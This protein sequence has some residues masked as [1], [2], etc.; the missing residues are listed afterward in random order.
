MKTK[1][2][3]KIKKSKYKSKYSSYQG[4]GMY[5]DN[6][7][8]SAGQGPSSTSNI[9]YEESDP[10]LQEERLAKLDAGIQRSQQQAEQTAASAEQT[11]EQGKFKAESDATNVAMAEAQ[12]Q[13]AV[14]TGISTAAT[15]AQ[16]AGLG[17][18]ALK[19][20]KTGVDVAKGASAVSNVSKGA[21]ALSTG[22]KLGKFATSGAGIGLI[23]AAAGYGVKK[24]WG[25]KDPTTATAGDIAGS[26]LSM[27]GTGASIG[28]FLGPIGTVAGG[29]LGG[30]YG[31]VSSFFSA[32]KAKR[33]KEKAEREYKAKVKK[34]VTKA[35]TATM[36]NFG[37]QIA[38]TRAGELAQK[39]YSGYDLGRNVVAQMGGMRMGMPRYGMAA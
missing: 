31:G 15:L 34:V 19:A 4:G 38:S 3:K 20:A 9:V 14:T 6:T 1:K 28:S 11:I 5:E 30:I 18:K 24:L 10:R 8:A 27:A 36:K 23:G 25:D 29:V 13:A 39:T 35:N 17:A 26:A 16:K 33:A 2:I 22:A 32:R 21:Q 37:S 12:K 7:V